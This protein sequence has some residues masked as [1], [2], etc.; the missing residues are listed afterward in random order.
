MAVFEHL[1][2]HNAPPPWK[3]RIANPR[4]HVTDPGRMR[5]SGR[6]VINGACAGA[7]SSGAEVG[8]DRSRPCRLRWSRRKRCRAIRFTGVCGGAE[9]PAG[10]PDCGARG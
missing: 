6:P 4:P 7:T 3:V 5:V 10:E 9:L 8:G 1:R 2:A